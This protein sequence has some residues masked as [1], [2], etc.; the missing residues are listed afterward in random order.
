M[1]EKYRYIAVEGPIGAGKTSLARRIADHIRADLLL[2]NAGE[3]PFLPRFYQDPKRH[4]LAT[5]LFFLFQRSGQVQDLQQSDLF[6]HNTVADFLLDKDL[7][8]ARLNLDDDEFR[9]YQKIYDELQPRAPVP[10]LVIYLQARPD[11]LQA[12]VLGR[13]IDYERSIST[14]YLRRL[15]DSYTRYFYSYTAAPLFIVN[16]EH[17]NFVQSDAD[18]ALLMQQIQAMRGNREF[19]NRAV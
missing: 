13:G 12:R 7:L 1:L 18:F 19:F 4:A 10:D 6:R 16:C 17:L 2:E 3:N 9:L 14:D 11:I 5:Q 15:A 8:F